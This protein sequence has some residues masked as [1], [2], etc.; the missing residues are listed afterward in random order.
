MKIYVKY[1]VSLRCKLI[2]KHVLRNLGLNQSH[3]EAGIIEIYHELKEEQIAQLKNSLWDFGLEMLDEKRGRL[4]QDIHDVIVEGI[5]TGSLDDSNTKGFL[6]EKMG[7]KY[8]F[9]VRVFAEVMGVSIQRFV[10]TQRVEQAKELI[11]YKNEKVDTTAKILNYKNR[12]QFAEEFKRT[13]GL[14]PMYFRKIQK[15]KVECAVKGL[16]LDN[17]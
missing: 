8:A 15:L 14:T 3:V 7:R 4:I 5:Q 2:A 16:D 12:S 9:L 17:V 10:A 13:T 11:I 6:V 1:M